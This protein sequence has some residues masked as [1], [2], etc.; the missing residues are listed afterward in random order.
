VTTH[1]RLTVSERRATILSFTFFSPPAR[2]FFPPPFRYRV[3]KHQ[4][5]PTRWRPWRDG[6]H[7]GEY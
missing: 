6:L 1:G 7:A 5:M 3:R 4:I 2:P